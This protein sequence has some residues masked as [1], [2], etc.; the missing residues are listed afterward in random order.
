MFLLIKLHSMLFIWSCCKVG[1]ELEHMECFR[2]SA[3][4]IWN[5]IL[6]L[7]MKLSRCKCS[8]VRLILMDHWLLV[9]LP[10]VKT[11]SWWIMAAFAA[12]CEEI[13]L[14]CCWS[15]LGK[16]E[17]ILI[18][19]LLK[20]QVCK[21]PVLFK[22]LCVLCSVDWGVRELGIYL[23]VETKLTKLWSYYYS[24]GTLKFTLFGIF[25]S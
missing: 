22:E 2:G 3:P 6:Q 8:L 5:F 21:L 25:G 1:E 17:T 12:L 9:I 13:L 15:W 24:S 7:F 4:M 18:I 19:L 14:K 16:S 11:L 20:P 10:R 23:Q